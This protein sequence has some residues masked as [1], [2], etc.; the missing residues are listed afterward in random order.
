MDDEAELLVPAPRLAQVL[1]FRLHPS[2]DAAVPRRLGFPVAGQEG[3][4]IGRAHDLAIE[5][6]FG[7]APLGIHLVQDRGV[8]PFGQGAVARDMGGHQDD[9]VRGDQ[10]RLHQRQ[11]V[12]RRGVGDGGLLGFGLVE[13]RQG[14]AAAPAQQD[15]VGIAQ[16]LAGVAHGRPQVQGDLLHDQGVVDAAIA[17]VSGQDVHPRLGEEAH[18]RQARRPADGVHGDQHRVRGRFRA[19]QGRPRR[20]QA[21]RT[22]IGVLEGRRVAR[23]DGDRRPGDGRACAHS[24]GSATTLRTGGSL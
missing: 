24:A 17:A 3:L 7:I 1:Q 15:H 19:D 11:G 23:D 2:G 20:D 22:A 6:Q 21:H 8:E 12:P 4:G 13:G 14:A 16:L 5:V 10:A 18:D 9:P